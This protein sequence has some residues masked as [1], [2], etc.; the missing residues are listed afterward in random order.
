MATTNASNQ[1]TST[2]MSFTI[3]AAAVVGDVFVVVTSQNNTD[4]ITGEPAGLVLQATP[5]GATGVN[6][7]SRV[8]TCVIDGTT[9]AA[10]QV[11]TWTLSATRQWM[12]LAYGVDGIDNAAPYVDGNGALSLGT[13]M[14]MPTLTLTES[15]RLREVAIVKADGVAIT[16]VD[17]VTG[18][19]ERGESISTAIYGVSGALASRTAGV[20][21]AGTYGGETWPT[22]AGGAVGAAQRYIIALRPFLNTTDQILTDTEGLTDA[23]AAAASGWVYSYSTRIG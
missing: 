7:A 22:P 18:W 17:P 1:G 15:G 5:A 14:V 11:K 2:S 12:V 13:S 8:Y 6:M 19:T 4:V 21:A 9:N 10:G 23:V 16:G 20:A 3:P